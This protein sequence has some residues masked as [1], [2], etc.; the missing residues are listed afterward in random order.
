MTVKT[1]LRVSS[2]DLT[3]SRPLSLS[4]ASPSFDLSSSLWNS[5]TSFPSSSSFALR[6]PSLSLHFPS[7]TLFFFLSSSLFQSKSFLFLFTSLSLHS[8][9]LFLFSGTKAWASLTCHF[10][11]SLHTGRIIALV[12]KRKEIKKWKIKVIGIYFMWFS[13][14]LRSSPRSRI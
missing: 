12:D 6:A 7:H 3:F 2:C 9:L 4:L 5:S 1:L 8:V 11:L 13:L 10:A 14:F